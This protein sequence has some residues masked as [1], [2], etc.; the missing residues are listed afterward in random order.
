MFASIANETDVGVLFAKTDRDAGQRFLRDARVLGLA[1]RVTSN[2]AKSWVWE[3]RVKGRVRRITLGPQ[4]EPGAGV[5][6][7]TY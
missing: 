7:A 2:G 3:G 6:P 4:L 5:G 1:L